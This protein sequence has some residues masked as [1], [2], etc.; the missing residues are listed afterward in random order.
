MAKI[1]KTSEVIFEQLT[2]NI[3]A[4]LEDVGATIYYQISDNG[5]KA[6]S[7]GSINVDEDFYLSHGTDKKYILDFLISKLGLTIL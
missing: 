7:F 5:N 4:N 2:A 3:S 6:V 1:S